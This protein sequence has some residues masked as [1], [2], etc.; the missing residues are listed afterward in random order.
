MKFLLMRFYSDGSLGT[1]K[2][3]NGDYDT[4]IQELA[5]FEQECI[6]QN[7][8]EFIGFL[9]EQKLNEINRTIHYL[10]NW[11]SHIVTALIRRRK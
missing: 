4:L 6:S 8:G 1:H 5:D 10:N 9:D 2:I 7:V 11:L 3:V